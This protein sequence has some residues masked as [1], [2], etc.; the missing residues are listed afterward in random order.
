MYSFPT[1]FQSQSS[2][3]LLQTVNL[4]ADTQVNHLSFSK[5]MFLKATFRVIVN[6]T[7]YIVQFHYQPR[8]RILA[9]ILK[10]ITK[11]RDYHFCV[12]GLKEPYRENKDTR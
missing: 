7:Q 5:N 10:I 8:Q 3:N 4:R 1:V 11:V 2:L 12:G 6:Q 9:E